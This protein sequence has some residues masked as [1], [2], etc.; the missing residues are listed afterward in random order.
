MIQFFITT[1][2]VSDDWFL[3][4]NFLII[5]L[6]KAMLNLVNIS[7]YKKEKN[8]KEYL[9]LHLDVPKNSCSNKESILINVIGCGYLIVF[10]I[11]MQVT[12]MSGNKNHR[13]NDFFASYFSFR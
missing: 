7:T 5:F 12:F 6:R 1:K 3:F 13:S 8:K 11:C 2:L 4:S 10:H 9:A